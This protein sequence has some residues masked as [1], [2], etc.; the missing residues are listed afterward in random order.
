MSESTSEPS[1]RADLLVIAL[2]RDFTCANCGGTDGFLQMADAGP[3][4]L[5]CADLDTL[6]FLS[7]GDAALT[8]R[9]K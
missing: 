2:V 1:A 5:T 9:R 8:R 3:L 7:A 6:V 4:C